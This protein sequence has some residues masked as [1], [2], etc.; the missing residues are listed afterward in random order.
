MTLSIGIARKPISPPTGIYLIGYGDRTKGNLGVHDELTA[1]AMVLD[2]GLHGAV[3]VACDLLAINEHTVARILAQ[4]G[5][6]VVICCSHTHSAP[7]TYADQHSPRRNRDYVNYLVAQIVK[8]VKEAQAKLQPARLTWAKGE[9]DIALN[10]RERKP[11]GTV[12]IGV[13]PDGPIDRSLSLVQ[14]QTLEGKPI[15]TLVNFQCHGTVLGP[16]N[17]LVSADWIGAMRRKVGAATGAPVMY[18]QGA[19]GDLNPTQNTTEGD[20]GAVD[21]LGMRVADRVVETLPL[22]TPIPG[23]SISFQQE[24]VWLELE[25]AVRTETPP[26]NYRR[27]L[28][29]MAHVPAFLVDFVLNARYPWKTHIAPHE[30]VWAVPVV[31]THLRVGDLAVIALGAEV[32]T[33]IGMS[34]KQ[35]SP[36]SHTLFASVSSGCIGYLPTAAEHALGGYEVDMS[37]YF[38]RMPGRLKPESAERVLEAVR[39]MGGG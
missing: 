6:S 3:I 12:E 29:K 18:L 37:P 32:F 35:A 36:A 27:V 19:T 30:G 34:I 8:A 13:N 28:A 31:L 9:A 1:T 15:A 2:D 22:L 39:E 10:R 24:Q 20:F 14:A 4:T 17:L 26:P 16:K 23:E 33:E 11:D 38:Y 7:I 21:A 25:A 5:S